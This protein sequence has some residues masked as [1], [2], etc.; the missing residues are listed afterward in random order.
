MI[1]VKKTMI[2]LAISGV[3]L[4]SY[5]NEFKAIIE[6]VESSIVKTGTIYK[7]ITNWVEVDSVFNCTDWT[8]DESTIDFGVMFTQYQDC[9]QKEERTKDLYS[10]YNNGDNVYE[11]TVKESRVVTNNYT[12]DSIGIKNGIV[13][14][15]EET[16]SSWN[17]LS[18]VYGCL[19]WS[20]KADTINYGEDFA[21]T[22]NCSQD[23]ERTKDIYNVWADG[24]E[25]FNR[26]ETENQTII[27]EETQNKVGTKNFISSSRED[28][29]SNWNDVGLHYN[30]DSWNPNVSTVNY[31]ASFTQNRNCSQNQER[32]RNVY[33][34]WADGNETLNHVETGTQTI[35]EQESQLATGT[36]N[37]VA[38][39]STSN[40]SWTNSGSLHSCSSWTPSTSTVNSGQSFTQTRVC[41]QNQVQTVTTYNHWA[42]GTTTVASTTQNTKT[43]NQNQSRAATGTKPITGHWVKKTSNKECGSGWQE[44][45]YPS[46]TCTIGATYS[47]RTIAGTCGNYPLVEYSG[48]KCE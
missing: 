41:K 27:V 26:T 7:N 1:N 4:F 40:G 18:S 9:Q 45:P 10:V 43:I 48:W 35:N 47:A 19:E 36:K 33:D 21:Q 15:R 28:V 32:T 23:Q 13:S 22:R 17:N 42:N 25:T 38:S 14:E 8:P 44:T 37:Y 12:Q 20:P 6:V 24:S 2:A 5:S 39:T 11:E 3:C 46:G 34:V 29:W 16:W 31:G 30:C